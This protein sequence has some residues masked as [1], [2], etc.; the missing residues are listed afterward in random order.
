MAKTFRNL[1]PELVSWP[2]LLHAYR[3]CR[4][5]KRYRQPA[6]AFDFAWEVELLQLQRELTSGDYLPGACSHFHISDPKPRLISAAPF[7][8]RVVHHAIV[9]VVEPI[10]ERSFVDDSYACRRGRGTHLAIRRAQH[11]QRRFGWC[12]K[13]DIVQFFPSVDHEILMSVIRRRVADPEVLRLIRKILE[14]DAEVTVA[15]ATPVW[16]PGDDLL[17]PLRAP[18]LP[19]GNLTSQFFANVLLDPI[20]HFIR[21]TLRIPGYVRYADDLLLFSDARE[22]LWE[23]AAA[24]RRRLAEFRLRLHPRKTHVQPASEWLTWLGMRILGNRCRLSQ[25]GIRR[26]IRR[27]RRQRRLFANGTLD[28]DAIRRSLHAWLGHV[29]LV[30]EQQVIRQ[31]TAQHCVFRR[32]R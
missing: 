3:R 10:F 32:S 4:R 29:D 20:D 13:T 25:Q 1:W 7:R 17:S 23:A 27:M 9:A 15:Q 11:Y 26:F 31:L 19:I 5:R 2:N 16:F 8:D 24:L 22:Q 12:L 14:S 21:E 18:G 30:T 6:T 28:A